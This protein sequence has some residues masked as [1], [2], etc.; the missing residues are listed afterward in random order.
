MPSCLGVL[1][2]HP[3]L[4][5]PQCV[6]GAARSFWSP[7]GSTLAILGAPAANDRWLEFWTLGAAQF[8]MLIPPSAEPVEWSPDGRY[9]LVV[10]GIGD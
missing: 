5:A 9:L 1:I 10:W 8:R 2:D 3:R 4:L 6:T 7:D